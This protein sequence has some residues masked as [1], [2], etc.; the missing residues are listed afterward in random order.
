MPPHKKRGF[1]KRFPN[2]SREMGGRGS[3]KVNAVRSDRREA[4]RAAHAKQGYLPTAVDFI[5]RCN[6]DEE[7]LEIINF[8]ENKGEITPSHAK[9]LREQLVK[10]G[11]RSFGPKR[12]PGCYEKE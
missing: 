4:E 3:I 2:L 5:R 7:A 6:N 12:G 11:L 1:S 9:K 10:R 8:L